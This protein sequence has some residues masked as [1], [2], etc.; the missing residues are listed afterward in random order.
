VIPESSINKESAYILFYIRKDV[1]S[2]QLSQ[3]FP[4]IESDIFVGKPVITRDNKQG[5]VAKVVEG[6]GFEVKLKNSDTPVL[7]K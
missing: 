5:F 7:L 1:A 4:N 3:I 2:K 6:H